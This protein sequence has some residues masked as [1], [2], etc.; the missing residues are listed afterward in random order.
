MWLHAA[1]RALEGK[2]EFRCLPERAAT[3]VRGSRHGSLSKKQPYSKVREVAKHALLAADE[4]RTR[5]LCIDARAKALHANLAPE[6]R[7][8][9]YVSRPWGSREA[10][11]PA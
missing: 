1:C 3:S 6:R 5:S 10:N 2:H 4:T 8:R 9:V 11:Y 7:R